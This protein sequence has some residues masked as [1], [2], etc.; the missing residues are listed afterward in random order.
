MCGKVRWW[1]WAIVYG[2]GRVCCI[3]GELAP[4]ITA[5]VNMSGNLVDFVVTHMGNDRDV[6]DRDL[7]A[8]FLARQLAAASVNQA[9]T[10]RPLL[11]TVYCRKTYIH[12]YILTYIL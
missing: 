3:T 4:A 10:Y 6:I 5:T 2:N 11:Y 12:A 8:K 1:F 9:R 7:Q